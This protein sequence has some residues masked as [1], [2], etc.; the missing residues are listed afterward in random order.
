MYGGRENGPSRALEPAQRAEGQPL[1]LWLE[2][3]LRSPQLVSFYT[4][5]GRMS[6]SG[7]REVAGAAREDRTEVAARG[8]LV[9]GVLLRFGR[10]PMMIEM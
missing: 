5:T 10:R 9:F 4:M 2:R 1:S 6:I 3:L 7:S 8:A